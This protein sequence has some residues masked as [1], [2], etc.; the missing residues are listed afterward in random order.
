MFWNGILWWQRDL[1]RLSDLSLITEF[2]TKLVHLLSDFSAIRWSFSLSCQTIICLI[3]SFFVCVCVL[4]SGSQAAGA[5]GCQH[6]GREDGEQDS[7]SGD[8]T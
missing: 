5:A 2:H 1:R 7:D 6:P 4:F 3:N 8:W